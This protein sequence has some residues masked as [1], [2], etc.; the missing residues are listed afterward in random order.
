MKYIFSAALI[1][2]VSRASAQVATACITTDVC[3]GLNIPSG[4]A[5]SGNGD[6]FFQISA[7]STYQWV[8]LGQGTG[9]TGSNIFVV[10]TSTDGKNVTLSPRLGTGHSEPQ[11]NSKAE[12][13]LLDGS[14]ISNGKMI[15]NVK[16]SNCQSWSGGSMDFTA[17]SGNWIHAYQSSG[18]ALNSNDQSA[19][20]SQHSNGAASAFSWS[21]ADAKGGSSVNPFVSTS[22]SASGS[23]T[24][25]VAG[26]TGA[27][28]TTSCVPR[29]TTGTFASAAATT[30]WPST[31]PSEFSSAFPSNI[32]S[33]WRSHWPTA[34]PTDGIIW[35]KRDT[36]NYCDSA[37]PTGVS[38]GN[39][40]NGNAF[41][42]L[43]SL[44]TRTT[45]MLIAHGVM[46]ALAFVILFPIGA[47][48]IRLLNFPGLLW[49]HAAFQAFAYLIFLIAFG[50]G[51]YIANN[52]GV[53]SNYH[54]IIGIVLFVLIFFQ[55]FFGFLHH[56]L[57]KKYQS[58]TFWSYVHIWL[59]RIVITLGII[60]G[61]LGFKLAD[62][63]GMG[64]HTGMIVYSVVA[65]IV[66]LVYVLSIVIGE[67][68]KAAMARDNPP[69][70]SENSYDTP[71][72]PINPPAEGGDS[73]GAQGYYGNG[74]RGSKNQ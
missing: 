55:P 2:L 62:T 7:P 13:S 33:E 16:C 19:T 38:G 25:S 44:N 69:K 26:A 36:V 63:M 65:A 41:T 37:S 45:K 74:H 48:S 12:V 64:S 56:S 32:P 68:R 46:A 20:I 11:F 42:I 30:T 40:G 18:G 6:I 9:M 70:Y 60:N 39:N 34:R 61:G 67:R 24:G 17:S 59:G 52:E 54:P 58:R 3:Y 50:L 5:S 72:A 21:F 66:W 49:F 15:A 73:P 1:G 4:T 31:M 35:S 27:T 14:G 10:Y 23:G 29:P 53:L 51:V 8:A 47:I 43:S 71:L 22:A 57:Y 28:G